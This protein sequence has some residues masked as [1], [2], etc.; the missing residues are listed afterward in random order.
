MLIQLF[1]LLILTFPMMSGLGEYYE[2]TMQAQPACYLFVYIFTLV[3]LYILVL[4][5]I[6]KLDLQ[7]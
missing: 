4:I 3:G 6:L 5:Q 1:T 2:I 7:V